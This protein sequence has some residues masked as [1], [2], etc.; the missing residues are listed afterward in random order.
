[1]LSTRHIGGGHGLPLLAGIYRNPISAAIGEDWDPNRSLDQAIRAKANSLL[2]RTNR[3]ERAKAVRD[4]K[5]E[6]RTVGEM[7]NRA[8]QMLRHIRAQQVQDRPAARKR[9]RS[10]SITLPVS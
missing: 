2:Q 9:S 1:M 3:R 5:L 8:E 10:V 4:G 6:P 7:K